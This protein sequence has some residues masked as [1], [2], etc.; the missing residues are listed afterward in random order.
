MVTGYSGN[1]LEARWYW[2]GPGWKQKKWWEV[3]TLRMYFTLHVALKGFAD[4]LDGRVRQKQLQM[5]KNF[6]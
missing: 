6:S 4:E 2:F 3:L 5:P 1:S